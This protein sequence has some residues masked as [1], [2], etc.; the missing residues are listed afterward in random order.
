[1]R[2]AW[3]C[4][5]ARKCEREANKLRDALIQARSDIVRL[6]DAPLSLERVIAEG[7][8][9]RIDSALSSPNAE[10]SNDR[11]RKTKA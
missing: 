6:R 11:E 1:M 5:H 8:I 3:M 2:F 9:G 4:D 10:L 7:S